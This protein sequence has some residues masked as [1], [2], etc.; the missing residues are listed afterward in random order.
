MLYGTLNVEAGD[1]P[2]TRKAQRGHMTA[3]VTQQVWG[4][5]PL[6]SMLEMCALLLRGADLLPEMPPQH[7][8]VLRKE[9]FS[10]QEL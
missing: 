7:L 2:S 10:S 3:H 4:L 1:A 8:E 9:D 5:S 6:C